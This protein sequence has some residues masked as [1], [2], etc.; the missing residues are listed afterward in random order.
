MDSAR[1]GPSG[2]VTF[3]SEAG[4]LGATV[5]RLGEECG[6]GLVLMNG[7]EER[8]LGA[9][10]TRATS[11]DKLVL[12][13]ARA[14]G[15]KVHR[16]AHYYFLHPPG[17]GEMAALDLATQIDPALAGLETSASF[18]VNM[19]L[20]TALGVLSHNL[21]VAIVADN[22]VADARTG[23]MFVE[24]APLAAVLE[25]VLQSARVHPRAITVDSTPDYVFIGAARRPAAP[26]ALLN[27]GNLPDGAREMLERR[28]SVYLPE[29]P[30]GAGDL[31]VYQA[32]VPL[33]RVLAPLSGQLGVPVSAD[34]DLRELP[35]NFTV[36]PDVPVRVAMDLL[37]R[38]WPLDVFGYEAAAGGLHLRRRPAAPAG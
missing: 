18:G 1:G 16:A 31:T 4:T 27:G 6:G 21:G 34:P 24:D 13:L 25:A 22:I 28:V 3:H 14:T 8:P 32:A 30:A 9:V 36:C 15:L 7:L 17:Y 33:S 20:F 38:Q 12:D 29:H 5:R 2:K 11:Y 35:V 37:I 19:P 23:E 10:S 26:A